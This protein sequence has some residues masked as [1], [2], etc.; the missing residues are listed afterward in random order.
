M[1]YCIRCG[2]ANSDTASFCKSCGAAIARP[3]PPTGTQVQAAVKD[4]G[5]R[6]E[7]SMRRVGEE[8]KAKAPEWQRE[9]DRTFGPLGPLIGALLGFSFVV[10]FILVLGGIATAAGGPAWVPALRDFFVTY[11]L[12]LL[13][14]MLLTSYS[15]YLMRRYKAQY[16]WFNP[17]ASAVAVVVSFWIVA[18]ILEVINRTVNSIVLE[19]FVTFLDVV[20]PIIVVL[21]L[22]I[23]Y[24]V[25]TVRFMGT[26][27][28]IR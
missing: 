12:L 20:L 24:L 9:W 10:V 6:F 18:R 13:G 1:A 7:E 14:V 27:Q 8:L 16:Q 3:I 5:A 25:L 21:A 19:G 28:P 15:S 22:V 17:I 2:M 23:G 4:A 11:M 26:Q